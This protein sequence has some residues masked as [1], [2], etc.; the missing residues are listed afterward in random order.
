M[1][2]RLDDELR[3]AIG[4]S[5]PAA[6]QAGEPPEERRDDA[7]PG[8][9]DVPGGGVKVTVEGILKSDQSFEASLV[10]AKCSSKYDPTSHEMKDAPVGAA[11]RA[12]GKSV[13]EK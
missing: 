12:G 10:M 1:S 2:T 13:A 4:T 3:L 7:G 9:R 11:P 5:K 6:A 8:R